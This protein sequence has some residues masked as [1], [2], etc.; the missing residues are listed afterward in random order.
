MFTTKDWMIFA[1]IIIVSVVLTVGL[2]TYS[3]NRKA[4]WIDKCEGA[5]GYAAVYSR[6]VGKFH[7]EERLCLHPSA[8]IHVE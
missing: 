4:I 6:M 2:A 8:V 3:E 7:E 1:A 5:G